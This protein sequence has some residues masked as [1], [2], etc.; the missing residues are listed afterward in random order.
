MD[1]LTTL[2]TRAQN[3]ELDAYG[4]IVRRFQDMA[5]GYAYTMLGDS[6]LAEDAAQEA[7]VRSAQAPESTG[8]PG[9]VPEDR[10]QALRPAHEGQAHSDGSPGSGV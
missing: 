4:T 7:F 8:V 3:G 5:V 10:V 2:V 1:S 6:H 9:L